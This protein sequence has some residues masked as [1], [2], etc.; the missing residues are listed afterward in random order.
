MFPLLLSGILPSI[1]LLHRPGCSWYEHTQQAAKVTWSLFPAVTQSDEVIKNSSPEP[2]CC[3]SMMQGNS[4]KWRRIQ[5]LEASSSKAI[6]LAC[7]L[8]N[9]SSN[10]LRLQEHSYHPFYFS[11]QGGKKKKQGFAFGIKSLFGT[12]AHAVKQRGSDVQLL[13][14]FDSFFLKRVAATAGVKLVISWEGRNWCLGCV[15]G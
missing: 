11:E 13:Y 7:C 4:D 9:I 3:W 15:C 14:A 10:L 6:N 8:Q 2:H 12:E 1:V 5:L